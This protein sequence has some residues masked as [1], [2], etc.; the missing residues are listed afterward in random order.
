MAEPGKVYVGQPGEGSRKE[1]RQLLD[2]IYHQSRVSDVSR[3]I[4]S[5]LNL[6]AL[7]ELIVEQTV[8]LLGARHCTVFL[9]DDRSDQLW[10]IVGTGLDKI[11]IRIPSS[12]GIAGWVFTNRR[13]LIIN[14]AYSDPRFCR[15]VD[16]ATDFTTHN[17]LCIPLVN[18]SDVCIGSLQAI[19]K[20]SGDF[21]DKDQ[22]LLTTVSQNITIALENGRLYE[23]LKEISEAR[24]K[25]IDHLSHELQTPVA[26]IDAALAIITRKLSDEDYKDLDKPLARCQ[27]NLK[28]LLS[29]QEKTSDILNYRYSDDQA[30]RLIETVCSLTEEMSEEDQ[31]AHVSVAQKLLRRLE[32]I[33]KI[34]DFTPE[35]ILISA[36]L[37]IVC[38]Q[39]LA[40]TQP[41]VLTLIRHIEP[42]LILLFD[43]TVLQKICAGLLKNAIEA[44]PDEGMIQVAVSKSDDGVAIA[45][46]D[47]GVGI[48][49]ENQR[50]LFTGFCHTQDT[51]YYASK[52]PYAFC[53]GGSGL[54]LLRIKAFSERF[55]FKVSFTSQ[56]CRHI[57][58]PTTMCPGAISDCRFI[59]SLA[60]CMAAGGST[61]TLHF[62]V[63]ADAV[64]RQAKG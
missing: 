21:T 1:D 47:W 56:G 49:T 36:F 40:E 38:D 59:N 13:P 58:D 11:T 5:E 51:A 30:T 63:T 48:T 64:S 54:D 57:T 34:G 60:D 28:R 2:Q 43:K 14:D 16:K 61:F 52:H 17:V 50:N 37:N 62:P 29:M 31:T 10:A 35:P 8:E 32:S 25:V 33:H 15:D 19:N 53:A 22:L 20:S 27:R 9:H 4:M 6:A 42:G 18:R 12:V 23:S 55:G 39:A 24:K 44:T 3:T 41:R 45:F 46:Q 26:I 7:I